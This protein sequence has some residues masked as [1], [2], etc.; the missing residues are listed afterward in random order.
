MSEVKQLQATFA[1]LRQRLDEEQQQLQKLVTTRSNLEHEIRTKVIQVA[2]IK[3]PSNLTFLGQLDL[4]RSR[5]MHVDAKDFPNHAKIGWLFLLNSILNAHCTVDR[6]S[7]YIETENIF[8]YKNRF[9]QNRLFQFLKR[10][11]QY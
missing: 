1:N 7:I 5:Q 10:G 2:F 11:K 4:H 9:C 6:R 3:K 8:F